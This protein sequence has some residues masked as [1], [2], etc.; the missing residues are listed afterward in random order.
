MKRLVAGFLLL[1][2]CVA[3]GV[4]WA[5]PAL[6]DLARQQVE[7]ILTDVLQ[8][9]SR[10]GGL[11]VSLLPPRLHATGVVLGEEPTSFVRIGTID[12][13]LWIL[14]SLSEGRLVL[15]T[16]LQSVG[17]DLRRMALPRTRD[18]GKKWNGGGFP[19]LR[20]KA[21]ELV[22]VH[23]HLRLQGA[24]A[25]LSVAELAGEFES[26]ARTPELR[27]TTDIIG[28][29]FERRGAQ[30]NVGRAHFEGGADAKGI[31][32]KTAAVQGDG[33][34]VVAATSTARECT[35]SGSVNLGRL[36]ALVDAPIQGEAKFAA[37]V[38]G[39]LA[40]PAV[41]AQLSVG[42]LAVG[43]RTVG[44]VKARVVRQG[45]AVRVTEIE[46]SGP[47]GHAT[48]SAVM[49]TVGTL[50]IEGTVT[51]QAVDADALLRTFGVPVEIGQRIAATASLSGTLAPLDLNVIASGDVAMA[52]LGLAAA[53]AR[54]AEPSRKLATVDAKAHIEAEAGTLQVEVL[55]PE[56]NR[57]TGSLSWKD[58]Q[59]AGTVDAQVRELGA[60][61]ALLPK[62][63]RRLGLTGR[64]AGTA[65]LS[66]AATG[67][68][69][70][71]SVAGQG[72]T[73]N[74]VPVPRFTGTARIADSMLMT[75][76][77]RIE[78]ARGGAELTGT[79]ALGNTP[80]NDWQLEMRGVDTN[81]V[82]GV[83]EA[84]TP[85]V[86]P[87]SGGGIDGSVRVRGA[88]VR[89]AIE[90][91]IV[92]QSLYLGAEPI[93][94]IDAQL[95][96]ELPRWAG[97]ASIVHAGNER[98]TV[99][100][101]GSGDTSVQLAVESTSW[102]LA[103][104][105][106]AS[107]HKL[108]GSVVLHGTVSG[109]PLQPSG[110]LTVTV[111]DV[112]FGD[113]Q[114]G[115]LRIQ[116][117]GRE[118]EW[119]LTGSGLGTALDLNA[120]LRLVAGF[121]YTLALH[122]HALDLARLAA[123]NESLQVAITG[124]ID[125]KGG[126]KS[127]QTPSGTVR[128]PQFD[129]RRGDYTVRPEEPIRIDV[130]DGRFVITPIVLV[131][132]SSRLRLSGEM[133]VSGD[134]DLRAQG[135]GDLVLLEVIGRP[136]HSA[137]GQFSVSAQVRHR[138]TTGWDLSGEGEVG[139]AAVDVGLPVAFT[140]VNGRFTL[141]GSGVQIVNLD[142]K[143]GGGQ[144][145][146]NGTLGLDDGPH[147]VWELQEV[148][149][150]TSRGLEAQMSGAGQVQGPWKAITVSGNIEV[151]N[152]LYDRNL[153]LT[154]FLP[155]FRAQMLPAP[156][157][158]PATRQILLD[159]RVRALGGMHIDNNVAEVEL[160]ARLRLAGTVESPDVSGTVE[161]VTGEVKFKQRVFTITGGA[162]D[163]RG[164]TTINPV[165]NISAEAQISTAETDYTITVSVTGTAE[166]PRVQLSAD[167]PT[168][169]ET[170]ILSLITF[171]QTVAQLQ[172][173]GGGISAI[174]AVAMLPTG[175]VT[176]PLASALGVN[177]LEIEAVQSQASG[178]TGTIEPRVTIGKD[179]TDRLRASVAT[180]FGAG[181][182][183]MVQLEYRVTRRISLLGSWEG[184]TSEQAGAFGGGI[185]FR[186][187]FR[188]LPFSL[189]PRGAAVASP[190]GQ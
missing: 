25:A 154:A 179:L 24:D 145:H 39:N 171:G 126:L 18:P 189:L 170:D 14:R 30:L 15:S 180:T 21:A 125:L 57:V 135:T 133:A 9:R 146:V 144:F 80:Q 112:S 78:T 85:V 101:S 2:L 134:V 59:L 50:P 35:L 190:Y 38:T 97:H 58:A 5:W 176:D 12:V 140:G 29:R 100:A 167:D 98:L 66:S 138:P 187:E 96:T 175:K 63:V 168:L 166:K 116:A 16:R 108:S 90:G 184:Q 81:L 141:S 149:L 60:L 185:K 147:L 151:L 152:A 122:L 23:V 79:M 71:A 165:L 4:W 118:G 160:G 186:Y 127:W 65:T 32:V 119:T 42:N 124:D 89:S 153:E 52:S 169:S 53:G 28:A 54:Q 26:T 129:I 182:Q 103:N 110:A 13:R 76:G 43:E 48:A 106:G 109:K 150:S 83:V 123:T 73:V 105:R 1:V 128:L 117:A 162:I 113:R 102:Q 34:D 49:R 158:K 132:P 31:F 67:L 93:D 51:L 178:T 137:R 62:Q 136:I 172:R 157:T 44:D 148:A 164:G 55:Q 163:F 115:E 107:R 99:E 77:M 86:I 33:I 75:S 70:Q 95:T 156:R 64:M 155:F 8:Q 69:L 142:G 17:L 82:V 161:F 56:Q 46:V 92:A 36:S 183:P 139:E 177:R 143:A 11:A 131:A 41:D 3:A 111:S 72:L 37:H 45:E 40:D 20:V 7:R 27:V 87:L 159:I 19:S 91:K 88:W 114:L 188:H 104:L 94:R 181:T 121:P 84:V 10:I 130:S 68:I 47:V 174:D 74:G 120:T 61:N 22:D 6:T 173:Q